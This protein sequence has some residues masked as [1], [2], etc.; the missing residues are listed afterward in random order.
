[1][2][3]INSK[4]HR[5]DDINLKGISSPIFNLGF[6][7]NLMLKNGKNLGIYSHLVLYI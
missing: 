2:P 3:S 6:N 5:V 7:S 1:M 4:L